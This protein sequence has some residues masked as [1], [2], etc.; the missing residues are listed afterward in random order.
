MWCQCK[1]KESKT[2]D[3]M[4]YQ[5]ELRALFED[6]ISSQKDISKPEYN[7]L[8]DI[9][10][11]YNYF[12][13]VEIANGIIELQLKTDLVHGHDVALYYFNDDELKY[14]VDHTNLQIESYKCNHGAI[15]FTKSKL[16]NYLYYP[17]ELIA[18][19]NCGIDK[20]SVSER[21]SIQVLYPD[22]EPKHFSGTIYSRGLHRFKMNTKEILNDNSNLN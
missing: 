16:D 13:V 3:L 12:E 6:Q 9:S 1:E 7:L 18:C 20:Y 15:P 22:F 14:I 11:Q 19:N 2:Y 17:D 10:I 4:D 5:I 8:R 21:I